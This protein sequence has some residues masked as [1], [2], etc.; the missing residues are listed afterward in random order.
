[1]K[2]LKTLLLTSLSGV[3]ILSG[4][5]PSIPVIAEGSDV[6]GSVILIENPALNIDVRTFYFLTELE[7]VVP[8]TATEDENN[9]T[10]EG[11]VEEGPTVED[12]LQQIEASILSQEWS[13]EESLQRIA[14]N[15]PDVIVGSGQTP[16]NNP[17]ANDGSTFD[18]L[19]WETDTQTRPVKDWQTNP[20][21]AGL[22]PHVARFKEEV[23]AMYGITSF[24][25][26]RPGDPQDHGK[27]LAV[28]FMVPVDSQVGDEIASYALTQML[29]GNE[30]I[31]Y[32]IWERH[33]WGDWSNGWELM[34]DRGSI[35]QNHYDHVHVSF[36][37]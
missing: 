5:I 10:S 17:P 29:N 14:S 23:A 30:R 25:L 16:A 2:N 13:A 34:E 15:N 24:S 19:S 6:G 37:P 12:R 26:F 27:G 22:Q 31:S 28:D 8:S 33:I 11:Q 1:M 18:I 4:L 21:N 7:E 3:T 36:Y 32:V 9:P 20:E 35:T